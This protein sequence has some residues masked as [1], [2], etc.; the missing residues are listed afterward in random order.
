MTLGY[1]VRVPGSHT[2]IEDGGDRIVLAFDRYVTMAEAVERL[3]GQR[4]PVYVH[5]DPPSA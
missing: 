3:A 2:P 4:L 5:R 1:D